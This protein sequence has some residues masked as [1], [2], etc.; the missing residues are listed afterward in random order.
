MGRATYA[1]T[2]EPAMIEPAIEYMV[3]YGFLPKPID[4][5]QLIWRP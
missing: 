3:K 1:T 2:L 4:A 5:S